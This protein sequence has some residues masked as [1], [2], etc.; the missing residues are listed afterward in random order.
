MSFYDREAPHPAAAVPLR[1]LQSTA[2]AALVVGLV[3]LLEIGVTLG[4]SS[5]PEE[6]FRA[7]AARALGLG[8]FFATASATAGGWGLAKLGQPKGGWPLF[9][10]FPLLYTSSDLADWILTYPG[11]ARLQSELTFGATTIA[12]GSIIAVV[13]ASMTHWLRERRKRQV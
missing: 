7:S 2:L 10:L 1:L 12:A 4:L 13:G 8:V 9:V 11:D 6:H 3:I 5:R